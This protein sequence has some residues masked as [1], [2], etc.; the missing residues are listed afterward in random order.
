[1]KK[2]S[3]SCVGFL[4]ALGVVVYCALISGVMRLGDVFLIETPMYLR[5]V[6]ILILLVFSAAV[7][8][9]LVFGYAAYLAL[10]QK[11]KDALL[12]VA[13][14]LLYCLGIIAGLM[15]ILISLY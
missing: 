9:S 11:I 13:Y 4:Q 5:I 3:L 10:Q 1:M 12:I 6:L 2:Y 7:T 15:I 8:V 14:T